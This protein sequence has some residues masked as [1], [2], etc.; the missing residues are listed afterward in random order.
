MSAVVPD[1]WY[2]LDSVSV[3]ML[4]HMTDLNT[5]SWGRK[6]V[7]KFCG[8]CYLMRK[9]G[10][11]NNWGGKIERKKDAREGEDEK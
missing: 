4:G 10:R 5:L 11:R 2:I 7:S 8:N 1:A 9:G 3:P 6:A